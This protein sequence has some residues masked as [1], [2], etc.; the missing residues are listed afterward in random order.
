M[1]SPAWLQRLIAWWTTSHP[2]L[3]PIETWL[4]TIVARS[5]RVGGI[6]VTDA[7]GTVGW[8]EGRRVRVER[9]TDGD[10]EPVVRVFSGEADEPEVE[11]P[12][13]ML[14]RLY[15]APDSEGSDV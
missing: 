2:F 8:I 15:H 13:M 14:E 6:V 4:A 5:P 3:N 9:C 11:P 12:S 7:S 10:G 1:N